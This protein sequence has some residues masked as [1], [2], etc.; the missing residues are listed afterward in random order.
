VASAITQRELGYRWRY[1]DY[2]AGLA[3]ILAEERGEGAVQQREITG[4]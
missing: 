2:R 3:A 4:P 1:P